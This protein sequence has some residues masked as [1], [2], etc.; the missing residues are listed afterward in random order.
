[1]KQLEIFRSV[2]VSGSITKASRRIGL[3]QPSISQQL[4]KLE[5][6]LE[7]QLIVRNRTG[8]IEMTPPGEYWF[9]TAT[10][11][12]K[13]FESAFAEHKLR[14]REGNLVIRLGTTPTLRGRFAAAV[15]R[16]TLEED[17]FARFEMQ[18]SLNSQEVVQELQLHQINIAIVN[19]VAIEGD[20]ASNSV[21]P[22]F[23]D[24]IAWVV[25]SYITDADI[26][27]ALKGDSAIFA[28]YPELLRYVNIGPNA[29]MQPASD[30]WY[31]N[32]LPTATPSFGTMTYVSAIDL[33]AEGICTS[34]C[35][36]SLLPNV[37]MQQSKQLRWI[38]MD[39]LA[40]EIVLVIPKHLLSIPAYS[41]VHN[42]I[43]SFVSSEYRKEMHPPE[44]TTLSRILAG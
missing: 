30:S 5:E 7:T 41:R 31:R 39:D 10:D 26:K 16:I 19:S 44:V 37:S 12:T 20:Q 40:R 9:K 27:R 28:Q 21:S 29:P 42:K 25:P 23:T 15:A 34:H 8:L 2:V 33:V 13:Q 14:F 38:I 17:S 11:L 35:P 43:K 18:Y 36:L 24:S 32:N 6:T 1:M 4:A 3:S 22:I